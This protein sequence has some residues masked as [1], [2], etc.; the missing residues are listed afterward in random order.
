MILDRTTLE[1]RIR[2]D[3]ARSAWRAA[4]PRLGDLHPELAEAKR[5]CRRRRR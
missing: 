2:A 3:R 1:A 4:H 5:R